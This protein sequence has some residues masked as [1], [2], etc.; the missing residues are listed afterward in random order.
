[1]HAIL[2]VDSREIKFDFQTFAFRRFFDELLH[3][4]THISCGPPDYG[5]TVSGY[6]SDGLPC[7][8]SGGYAHLPS[9]RAHQVYKSLKKCGLTGLSD[10]QQ[11]YNRLN[12]ALFNGDLPDFTLVMREFSN[13]H[14]TS[15]MSKL[16]V[17][18]FK[19]G[20]KDNVYGACLR[21]L[22]SKHKPWPFASGESIRR[23]AAT[24]NGRLMRLTNLRAE[25]GMVCGACGGPCTTFQKNE[26]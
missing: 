15:K 2:H 8:H 24:G 25:D 11:V 18:G 26:N 23:I 1:M 12:T 16:L 3:Q 6:G 9:G 17:K 14:V 20:D 13:H 10:V 4:M 22:C 5:S 21:P 7:E 19:D